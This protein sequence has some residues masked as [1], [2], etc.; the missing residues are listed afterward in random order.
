MKLN[1]VSWISRIRSIHAEP[2]A[3]RFKTE[4]LMLEVAVKHDSY[5]YFKDDNRGL[6]FKVLNCCFD[7]QKKILFKG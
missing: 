4:E 6:F 3:T 2:M 5:S 7:R 1:N